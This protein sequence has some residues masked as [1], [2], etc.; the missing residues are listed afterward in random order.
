MKINL[1]KIGKAVLAGA[2]IL[3]P[4]VLAERSLTQHIPKQ[5]RKFL[6]DPDIKGLI[7]ALN[8]EEELTSGEK[9]REAFTRVSHFLLK[10]FNVKLPEYQLNLLIE[11]LVSRVK[12]ESFLGED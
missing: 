11:L 8:A 6:K 4:I 12:A 1:S 10:K 7:I 2:G 9:R 5:L 3:L